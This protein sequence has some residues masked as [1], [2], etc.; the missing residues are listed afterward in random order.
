MQ[1]T[2]N[3]ATENQATNLIHRKSKLEKLSY[4]FF[5]NSAGT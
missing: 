3:K 5:R 2:N 4:E 1:P